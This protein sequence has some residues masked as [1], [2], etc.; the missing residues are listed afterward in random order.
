MLDDIFINPLSLGI[1]AGLTL[2]KPIGA[3]LFSRISLWL[4]LGSMPTNTR[5]SHL[6]AACYLTSI[7]FTMS[8]FIADLNYSSQQGLLVLS[9]AAILM[10][11]FFASFLAI[12]ALIFVETTKTSQDD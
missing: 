10:S 8:I 11:S 4:K 9:K 3:L 2:G 1:L 7:G 5:F 6:L 12:T